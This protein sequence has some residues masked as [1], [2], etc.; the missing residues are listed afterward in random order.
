MKRTA[1][2]RS[3]PLRPSGK[4]LRRSVWTVRRKPIKAISDKARAKLPA[5]RKCVR[6]VLERDGGCVFWRRPIEDLSAEQLRGID[7]C[8][9]PLDVHEPGHRSQGADPTDPDQC[10]CV[11]RH[12]HSWA[13]EHPVA[14]KVLG[15]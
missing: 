2:H 7:V 13:H 9:G 1:L 14:A 6:I 5:R 12:H 11:C 15:L 10:V 4:P 3:T 8:S